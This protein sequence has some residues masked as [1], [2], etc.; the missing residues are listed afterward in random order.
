VTT[1]SGPDIVL[2]VTEETCDPS[3]TPAVGAL[4][5]SVPAIS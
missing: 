5:D 3:E 1:P 4:I 2:E